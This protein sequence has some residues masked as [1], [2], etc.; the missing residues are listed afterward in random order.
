MK[1]LFVYSV[2]KSI[3]KEKPLLGQEGI[4][5]GLSYIA[6]LLKE[7]GH[8]CRLVILDRK[9]KKHNLKILREKIKNF[10]PEIIA[11]TA[12]FSEF[13]FIYNIAQ[14]IKTGFPNLFL[15]AGGVHITLN[16]KEEYLD[17][18]DAICIGEGEFPT[19]E[20][21][22]RLQNGQAINDIKNIW[23]KTNAGIS[24]NPTR[25]FVTDLD[26]FPFPDR[27][28]W[29]EW[30][31]EP[32]TRLT[33]LV[34]RGCP[35]NCTY[36]SNHML[37]KVSEG[38][39]VRMRSPQNII[40][41]IKELYSDF[42]LTKEIYLE[43]E[44]IAV[45]ITWLEEFCDKLYEFGKQTGFKIKFGT[46]LRIFPSLDIEFVFDQ[47]IKA[48][49]TSVTIGLESGS[50]RIRK[51]ILNRNYSN[52]LILKTAQIAKNK[53]IDLALF[54]MV[55][56]P[57]ETPT[58]FS[59]TLQINQIVQPAYHATSIFFPYPGTKLYEMC[60][61][62][63]LLPEKI[64]TKEE[65]QFANLDLPGFPKKEIQKS[66]DSFH[67]N[68]YKV[69]ENKSGSKSF[70]Y[71]TMKY[72]GHNFYSNLKIMLIRTLYKTKIKKL[73]TSNLFSIFQKN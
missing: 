67:Y 44:T 51:D 19:L 5:L 52:E 66:F 14:A 61:Q 53:G 1:I 37:K 56:L 46:N 50:F 21:V 41:E 26:S 23:V 36:C 30:I 69:K 57:T 8:E 72:L 16:P 60:E 62:M 12:V 18:F 49:I 33:I 25:P 32:N 45:D 68:V 27:E 71:F 29:Q 28:M 34:G 38:K 3:L 24:K 48:N 11:F 64:N 55:G 13:E 58:E 65:R 59:E 39:Y 4:Y 10:N 47:F 22:E 40:S 31:L 63:G 7:K 6:G 70:L 20:L 15:I 43:V 9:Y 17:V 2:Q 54:N 73:A 35:F 42:P